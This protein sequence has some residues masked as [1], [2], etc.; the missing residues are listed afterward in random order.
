[1]ASSTVPSTSAT[2]L[3]DV[4]PS[5]QPHPLDGVPREYIIDS[6]RKLAPKFYNDAESSD[7]TIIFPLDPRRAHTVMQDPNLR[8]HLPKTDTIAAGHDPS[9]HGRR[10]TEPSLNLAPARLMMR[11]HTDYLA[12]HSTMFRLLFSGAHPI[13]LMQVMPQTILDRCASV[14]GYKQMVIPR[15]LPSPDGRIVCHVPLPDPT[16]FHYIVMW[17][18]FGNVDVLV[19][20]AQRGLISLPGLYANVEWLGIGELSH[21]LREW[22]KAAVK[23]LELHRTSHEETAD[24]DDEDSDAGCG[25]AHAPAFSRVTT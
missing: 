6:L 21:F 20:A 24:A 2:T 23:D 12:A 10:A 14:E 18:Y 8:L 25:R 19:K 15:V 17:M 7:C 9:G 4:R 1:M 16:S 5:A 13:D 11:L 22:H 3:D